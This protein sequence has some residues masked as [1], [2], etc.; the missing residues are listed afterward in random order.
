MTF[1]A[2]LDRLISLLNAR[3]AAL[4]NARAVA[5]GIT[6]DSRQI[7]PGELF[8]ALR[9]ENFD[10]HR[11]AGAAIEKGAIA[12]LVDRPF[13]THMPQLVVE[14]TLAAYQAIARWWRDRFAI[15]IVAVTGS[16]GKTTTKEIIAAVLG[17]QGTVLKT[18]ANYNNEIGVPK[19]LLQ[20]SDRH[21]FAVIEMA[22]RGRGQI[23]ELARVARPNVSVIVNVGTAHI[24][25]L[26]SREAIAEA[27][28]ELL[29][30]TDPEG[31]AILHHDNPLLLETARRVWS[32]KTIT[33]GLEGGDLRPMAIADER[34][35][36]A[37]DET[38]WHL[39]LPLSGRHN[40]ANYLAALG[41][42]RALQ[43]SWQPLSAGISV[44]LPS[45]RAK[46]L[47]LPGDILLLDETYNAGLESAIAA[48]H[49]LAATPGDRHV[50]VLGTMKELGDHS[51]AFH[52]QVGEKA[53]ELNLDA[54]FIYA[55]PLEAEA[56]A[57]GAAGLPLVE[58]YAAGNAELL[59]QR[60]AGL[61]KPRDRL[62]F[63]ASR[64]VALDKVVRLVAQNVR[65]LAKKI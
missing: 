51:E 56:M 39:P 34:M 38:V 31:V 54:L 59:A 58:K 32:G 30:D 9:G 33:F 41:V 64:S 16:V 17:T 15:P 61:V 53:R 10:G 65:E 2:P 62:L 37:D 60:L 40:A 20:L 1:S 27:K 43:I 26:G 14:D 45:G 23:A 28:C 48:L 47:E 6:T 42:A 55:E 24:G 12:A 7:R 49:L 63:K 46:R 8:V 22:M 21:D 36:I 5:R 13:D 50:A 11:F 19:T 52:R 44:E 3:P 35:Q 18:E 57:A 4:A 29:A 25:L